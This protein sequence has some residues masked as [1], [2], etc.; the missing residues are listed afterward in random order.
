VKA[1]GL[2]VKAVGDRFTVWSSGQ[3]LGATDDLEAILEFTALIEDESP[4]V[5][6]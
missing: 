4:A 1:R 5:T 3:Q 2:A 6:A